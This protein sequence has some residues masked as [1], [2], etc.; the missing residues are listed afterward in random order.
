MKKLTGL[1]LFLGVALSAFAQRP[2]KPLVQFTGIVHNADS[3]GVVI[4]YVSITNTSAGGIVNQSNYKGYF[5][6]VVHESDTV[7][8]SCVGYAAADIVIPAKVP[9]Q[10]YTVQVLLKPQII[11]L[12]VFRVFPWATTE[13]FTKDFLSMKIAD[14]DLA[15]ARKNLSHASIMELEKTLPRDGSEIN[16]AQDFHNS[17]VN[18]HFV[19]NSLLNPFAW[20]TLI[21]SISEGDKSRGLVAPAAAPS[22]TSGN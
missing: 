9:S 5:S 19:T 14:D 6:F 1:L 17:I 2:E 12:P 10:S 8:F 7:R 16:T 20:G 4:P 22:A 15:I 18:S 11:N 13:E 21:R 3:T